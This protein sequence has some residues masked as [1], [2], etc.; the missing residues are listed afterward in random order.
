MK[1]N[2]LFYVWFVLIIMIL[3]YCI[4]KEREELGCFRI[5]IAKQCNEDKSVY[6]EGT[7]ASPDDN[8]QV[9]TNKIISA[10]SYHEKA[11]IWR[12]CVILATILIGILILFDRTFCNELAKWMALHI[13]F[14][15][16]FYFFFNYLNYHHFRKLKQNGTESLELLLKMCNVDTEKST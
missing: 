16:I 8:T 2:V 14:F 4:F 9:L 12:R 13:V 5:S 3:L 11:G 15:C 6:I 1:N 10:L 7:K